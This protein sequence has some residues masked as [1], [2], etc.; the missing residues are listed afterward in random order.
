[1]QQHSVAAAAAAAQC[2][3]VGR[4]LANRN[5]MLVPGSTTAPRCCS[6]YFQCLSFPLVPGKQTVRKRE[7]RP[8][9]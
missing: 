2:G 8:Q 4:H 5:E 9:V 7:M 6:C 1:M 3:R